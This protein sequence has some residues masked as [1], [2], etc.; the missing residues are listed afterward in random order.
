V[1][2][3]KLTWEVRPSK[4]QRTFD[5]ISKV[6]PIGRAHGFVD[7]DEAM[8]YAK[9]NSNSNPTIIRVYD[10]SGNVIETHE[11]AGG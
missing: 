11:Y 7:T 2:Q 5:L 4:Y 6:L 8:H 3:T 9:A 10:E 1:K